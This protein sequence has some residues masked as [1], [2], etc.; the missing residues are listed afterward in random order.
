MAQKYIFVCDDSRGDFRIRIFTVETPTF[1]DF[2]SVK[3]GLLSI[4]R[5]ADMHA[6]GADGKWYPISH[7]VPVTPDPT[8]T[9]GL[10]LHVH[11]TQAERELKFIV[12]SKRN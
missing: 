9:D 8:E 6:F 10:P 3:V 7:G 12:N 5:L 11:I 4:I 1:A 2:E